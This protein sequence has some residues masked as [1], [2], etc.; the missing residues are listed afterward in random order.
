MDD[1]ISDYLGAATVCY[2]RALGDL[3]SYADSSL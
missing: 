2:R 1:D 3:D